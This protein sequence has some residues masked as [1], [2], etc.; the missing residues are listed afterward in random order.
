VL[1]A[2]GVISL[3]AGR[4]L[5]VRELFLMGFT[6]VVLVLLS[7]LL[8]AFAPIRVSAARRVVPPRVHSG[9]PGRVD[10]D[11][12]AEGTSRTPV[13]SARDPFDAGRRQARFRVA[14]L[15]PG[16]TV[17]SAYRVPTDRR[18]VFSLGPLELIRTD[19]LGLLERTVAVAGTDT[20]TVYPAVDR[21]A[22]LPH[23]RGQDPRGG[24][25]ARPALG[26]SGD[27]FYALRPYV[28]GDDLRR[29]HWASSARLDDLM[30]RQDELPWQGRVVV[31]VDIR[32]EVH[33][34]ASF[35]AAMSAAASICVACA[36]GRVEVRLVGSDGVD[37]AFGGGRGHV[38]VILERLAG[39][40]PDPDRA[41]T[42]TRA[43]AHLAGGR[44]AALAVLTTARAG[45][46][47]L[48][49]AARTRRGPSGTTIV[50]FD[51]GSG[52]PVPA[53][54]GMVLRCSGRAGFVKTWEATFGPAPHRLTDVVL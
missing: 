51:D 24:T 48:E 5:G 43:L 35:E 10:L 20:L 14:P 42:L 37:T 27:D 7:W 30:I 36:A 9:G 54:S 28:V 17:H 50:V 13:L 3:A 25:I 4:V 49:A 1:T 32:A 31:C 23:T 15:E 40:A 19:P 33:S 8:V 52:T 26:V 2:A 12:T 6:M 11:L 38:E 22:A 47:G 39:W 18:G 53:T 44:D 41:N 29:V 34:E 46:P 16:Q 21:I 45:A